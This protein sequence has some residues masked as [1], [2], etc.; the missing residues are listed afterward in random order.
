ML[1]DPHRKYRPFAQV[2]LEDRQWPGRTLTHPPIWLSTDLRDG[3]QSLFEPMSRERKLRFFT[4]LCEIGF[5]EIEAGFPAASQTEFDFL[6]HLIDERLVP[7]DVTIGVLTQA[8]EDLIR[9]T[10]D[11]VIGAKRAIVHVYNATSKVFR[12]VVFGLPPD[13]VIEMAVNAVRQIRA[14]TDRHPQTQWVLEYSPEHFTATE[15]PFAKQVCDAVTDAW[16][17]T[18]ERKVILNLPATVELSTPNILADQIEWMHRHLARRDSV[19]L[20]VHPHNDR[21]TAI[22][23]AELAQMAGADRVEGCLFGNGER[24][25]NVDIVTLALN[26]YTQGVNP[27]LDFSNINEVARTVEYC[28]QL[29]IHPRHPYVGDLVFTAFS[30]SHQDGIKKGMAVQSE[31][32]AWQVPYLP[33]DPKDLG[34]T[35]ESIIRINSQ[36][37]KGGISYLL[38]HDH[39]LALPRRLQVEFSG[40]VQKQTDTLGT[41]VTSEQLWQLFRREYLD[42]SQPIAVVEHHLVEHGT[43][44][45]VRLVLDVEGERIDLSGEGNGPLDAVMAALDLPVSLQSYEER[46]IG[47]G[48]AARAVAYI[49]LSSGAVTGGRFG[50]AIHANI[51]TASIQAL[52]SGLNR[53][54]QAMDEGTRRDLVLALQREPSQRP[55]LRTA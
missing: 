16:A 52:F 4:M 53:V 40:V 49:E 12:D 18:P 25:G 45:A 11:S 35:Y 34:R 33:I 6:R 19:V 41:E 2:P 26:L 48:A 47:S 24:T 23:A 31:D 50:V 36:S 10:V 30:G 32:A 21:G 43:R 37:G 14:L 46:A 8:R 17:A 7:D 42:C 29:P 55:H 13:G 27:G 5:K 15:L 39:G 20:S 38:E 1:R 28:N 3:N 22:A 9:R 44:Q 54:L 51:I